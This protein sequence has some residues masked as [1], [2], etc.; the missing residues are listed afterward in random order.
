MG[1]TGDYWCMYNACMAVS[2]QIRNVPEDI[3]DQIAQL[4]AAE[5][6]SVQSYLLDLLQREAR[7]GRNAELFDRTAHIRKPLPAGVDP[8]EIVREGRDQGFDLDREDRG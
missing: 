8:E 3:R 1:T 2:L 6:Q 7:A 4:A 5:G